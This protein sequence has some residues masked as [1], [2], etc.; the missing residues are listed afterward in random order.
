MTVTPD[1]VWALV[2]VHDGEDEIDDDED[3]ETPPVIEPERNYLAAIKLA[4][5]SQTLIPLGGQP[6]PS[7]SAP[8]ERMP[9]SA[10][11]TSATKQWR[12]A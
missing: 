10:L 3:P 4:D 6:T 5:M 7:P 1:G 11:K 8:T 2:V 9:R 12:K